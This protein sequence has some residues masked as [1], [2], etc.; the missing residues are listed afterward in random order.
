VGTARSGEAA[1]QLA[2]E[3]KPDL[4][5]MDVRIEGEEDGIEL[6][7]RIRREHDI[8]IVFLTAYADP[9]TLERA[10][11]AAPLGYIVKP[12]DQRDI[13]VTVQTAL[14]RGAIHRD[15]KRAHDDLRAVLDSQRHGTLLVDPA[16]RI[17]FAS[18]ASLSMLGKDETAVL[19]V[20]CFD[21]LGIAAEERPALETAMR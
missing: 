15:L 3:H 1:F 16:G 2:I 13:E 11:R 6:A 21:A 17:S 14:G 4:V 8:P 19:G 10:R 12:F 18:R 5:L 7:K 20:Q 9:T